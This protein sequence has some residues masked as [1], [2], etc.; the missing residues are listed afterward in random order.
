M[1]DSQPYLWNLYVI[2]NAEDIVVFIDLKEKKLISFQIIYIDIWFILD[3]DKAFKGTVVIRAM[4][5]LH[6]VSLEITSTVL[7]KLNTRLQRLSLKPDVV[8]L[9]FYHLLILLWLNSLSLE[10][11]KLHTIRM[12]MWIT[13]NHSSHPVF[14]LLNGL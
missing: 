11:E 8:D 3:Q 6:E 4:P 7:L 9:W 13:P 10:Y 12:Y 2:N 5:S 14:F 1:T